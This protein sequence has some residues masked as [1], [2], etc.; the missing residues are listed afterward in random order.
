MVFTPECPG[1][2]PGQAPV[3][4]LACVAATPRSAEP[5]HPTMPSLPQLAA[6]GERPPC[7]A[8]AAI[9]MLVVQAETGGRRTSSLPRSLAHPAHAQAFGGRGSQ[10]WW[11]LVPPQQVLIH[12]MAV[13]PGPHSKEVRAMLRI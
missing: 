13:A 7:L 12:V 8:L 10:G 5:H 6:V 4:V 11:E 2:C 9:I 3:P 1:P